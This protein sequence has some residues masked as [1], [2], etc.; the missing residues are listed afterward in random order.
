MWD[1]ASDCKLENDG[2]LK[3][4]VKAEYLKEESTPD[5]EMFKLVDIAKPSNQ[6][7]G[8]HV[9]CPEIGATMTGG[10]TD[11]TVELLAKAE[12]QNWQLEVIFNVGCCAVSLQDRA[13]GTD[14]CGTVLLANKLEDYSAK[15]KVKE[16]VVEVFSQFYQLDPKW[17][18]YLSE[19]SITQ[20]PPGPSDKFCIIPVLKI[21][22]ISSGALVI[23]D[24]GFGDK[25]RGDVPIAG[26]E[27]EGSGIARGLGYK[28]TGKLPELAIV[29]AISDFGDESKGKPGS[30]CFFG[31]NCADVSDD[32]RQEV[33]TFHA[34]ALVT[35]CVA[36]KLLKY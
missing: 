15:G 28:K 3:G 27:M 36:V 26:I 19:W 1:E 35:R 24:I 7:I 22:K 6:V 12:K 20:P 29:K 8:V 5:Y 33:A 16:S 4:T 17:T 21:H 25:V 10:S 9:K 31:K 13:K 18:S 34:I 30:T 11:T 14:L 2:M 23:K 32:V